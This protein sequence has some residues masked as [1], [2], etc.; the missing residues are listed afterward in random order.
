MSTEA[1]KTRSDRERA[2]L[3]GEVALAADFVAEAR[4]HLGVIESVVA[5][6]ESAVETKL[7][8]DEFRRSPAV[9]G[10]V[11]PLVVTSVQ[12]VW[13]KVERLLELVRSGRH[14]MGPDE[15]DV[16]LKFIDVLTLIQG[17]SEPVAG[18]VAKTKKP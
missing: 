11:G 9:D 7:R 12:E 2:T 17:L 6:Y 4:D 1:K 13:H 15:I 18:E 5:H 8:Q 10:N 16:V 3:P 14:A